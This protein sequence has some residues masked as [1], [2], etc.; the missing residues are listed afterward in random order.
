LAQA[1]N[2]FVRFDARCDVQNGVRAVIARCEACAHAAD[3]ISLAEPREE[4]IGAPAG[5]EPKPLR[6]EGGCRR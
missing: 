1:S 6:L 2:V 3:V 4:R 5:V